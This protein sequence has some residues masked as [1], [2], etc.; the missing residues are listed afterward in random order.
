MEFERIY[1]YHESGCSLETCQWCGEPC[2]AGVTLSEV[3]VIWGW[4]SVSYYVLVWSPLSECCCLKIA[5]LF[6]WGAI[7][8]ERT[9]L[10]F[11]VPSLNCPSRAEPVTIFYCL[12]WNSPNLEGQVPV[13]VCPSNRV[14]L[15]YSRT[16][17]CSHS[18]QAKSSQD[19][20]R[21]TVSRPVYLGVRHPSRK[22]DQFFS[23]FFK[24]FSDSY[25]FSYVGRPLWRE[26]MAFKICIRL[27]APFESRPIQL[28][29]WLRFIAIFF[30]HYRQIRI[31]ARY[32]PVLEQSRFHSEFYTIFVY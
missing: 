27:G 8:D 24:L 13:F 3:E 28:L 1:A 6:L 25:G 14:A 26:V 5:V 2:F 4:H 30:G 10:Q 32:I 7:S 19:I 29:E 11:T 9:G 15:L 16:L 22:R 23:F 17:G 31:S 21:L 20:L 18:S 12:I